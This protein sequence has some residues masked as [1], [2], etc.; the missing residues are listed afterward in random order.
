MEKKFYNGYGRD[1][2]AAE[3]AVQ[4]LRHR[5]D[6][7]EAWTEW[8]GVSWQVY[9][10]PR[11]KVVIE[12]KIDMDLCGAALILDVGREYEVTVV[13][14]KASAEQLADPNTICIECG[15]S[16]QT[17][18]NNWDHHDPG[19]PAWS[20]TRQAY[21]PFSGWDDTYS[22]PH[23]RLA[24]Y[25]DQ[26]D[27]MGPQSFSDKPEFPS[28]S[29]VFAGMLLSERDPKEQ[30]FK[31]IELLKA[32]VESQ[33]DPYGTIQGFNS[34]ASAKAENDRQ[35][36]EVVK[37]AGWDTTQSGLRMAIAESHFIGALGA[38]YE[39]GAKVAIILNPNY[40]G[41]RKFTVA[42]NGIRVDS[43]LSELNAREAGWGGPPTGT[44]LGSDQKADSK[45]T[46]DE[47]VGIVKE[48]L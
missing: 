8:S 29:D 38:L 25:I 34:Y 16:G 12:A 46:L 47:V 21:G 22:T 11:K 20:A 10:E 48:T 41:I 36:A 28:L 43:I 40:N 14:G 45:L 18:L 39:S 37:S 32:V 35:V 5:P 42:G 33:Q 24:I 6:V 7:V 9:Y 23:G 3:E 2:M 26:L 4:E 1:R 44:I 30:F 13:R 27:T 15:G 31:G 19:G 17:K